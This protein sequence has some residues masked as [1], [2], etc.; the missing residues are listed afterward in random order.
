MG[1]ENRVINAFYIGFVGELD[2]VGDK[3]GQETRV[4]G[5]GAASGR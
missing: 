4:Y 1:E 5:V 3:Q 2:L